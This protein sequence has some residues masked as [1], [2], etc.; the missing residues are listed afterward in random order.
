MRTRG[1]A[2][3]LLSALRATTPPNPPADYNPNKRLARQRRAALVS[4]DVRKTPNS[5]FF[6]YIYLFYIRFTFFCFPCIK[7]KKKRIDYKEESLVPD[8][9]P[10]NSHLTL[11]PDFYLLAACFFAFFYQTGGACAGKTASI[12]LITLFF[13]AQNKKD[14]TVNVSLFAILITV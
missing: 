6:P 7:K 2:A 8:E 13:C 4:G 12:L 1:Q 11:N 3:L 5:R 14:Y 10:L 9:K